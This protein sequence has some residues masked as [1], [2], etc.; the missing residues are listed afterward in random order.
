[1]VYEHLLGCFMPEDPS[2]GFSELFQVVVAMACGDTPSLMVL[3]L[4]ANRLLVMA[5]NIG[6]LCPIVV[7]EVF[8]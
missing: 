3:V 1:M 4:G 6:G 8:L 7:G 2:S 5:K